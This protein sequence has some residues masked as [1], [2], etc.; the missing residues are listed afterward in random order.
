MQSFYHLD[1]L[2]QGYFN[3]DHDIINDDEDTVEGI[4]GLFIKAAPEWMLKELIEEVDD[5]IDNYKE[6]LDEEFKNR[7]G[8][9]FSP[10][11]WETTAYDFLITVRRLALS[12]M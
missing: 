11:L 3:Q 10:E 7:Y 4:I 2:I 12:S 6:H 8:Y 9:D 5:F 1:Q